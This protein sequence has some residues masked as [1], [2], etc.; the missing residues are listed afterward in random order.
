MSRTSFQPETLQQYALLA[1]GERGALIGPRGDIAF[2]C[3]PRWHDDAIFAGLLGGRGGYAVTPKDPR[4]TWGGSYEQ[5]SLIWRSRWVTTHSVIECREALAF[6]GQRDRLTLLRRIEPIMGDAHVDVLLEVRAEWGSRP[7]TVRRSAS[8]VWEGR[9]GDLSFRWSGLPE[10]ARLEDGVLS[11]DLVVDNGGR[12]DLVLEIGRCLP[13]D[14]PDAGG[15][16]QATADAWRA[17]QPDLSRSVAPGDSAHSYAVLRGLTSADGGMVAAATTSLP[18]RADRGNNY[19]YRYAWIRDQAYAG[20]AAAL[21]GADELLDRSV[22][23]VT[24]RVLE[25]GDKLVPAY[26]VDGARVPDERQLRLLGYPGAP[27]RLGNHVNGQFQLDSLGEALL[28][29]TAADERHG[30][31]HKALGATESLV[32]T[33]ARR[34]DEPDAGIWELGDRHW[35]H[36]R[37]M[38]V[39][40]LRAA[41]T[42]RGG[43]TGQEWERLAGTIMASVDDDCVHPDGRWQRAPDDRRVD[44]ALVLAGVRG[45]VAPDDPRQTRTLDAV[46]G[47]LADDGH[48]YRFRHDPGEPLHV[49]EGAFVLSG[50]HVALALLDAGDQT[51]ALRWFERNRGVPGPPG[52]FAEEFDVVQRQLR[53]NLPQAFVHA[54]VLETAHRLAD[55]GLSDRGFIEEDR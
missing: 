53:G 35:A 42:R 21:V 38:C 30:L 46:L 9:S 54:L 18:E 51:S 11:L 47:E 44:A 13:D 55:A 28:M 14:L 7:M 37:L 6:P 50:F 24:E 4:Y 19:D 1:D 16:W 48:V 3:A 17:A 34:W 10:H 29:L 49:M 39:A 43:D 33:I 26:T 40:G 52:L 36:S 5:G 41:A 45:A 31:D 2:L 32:K 20:Q 25:D 22:R 8:G 23:F 15:A 27:V 12:R